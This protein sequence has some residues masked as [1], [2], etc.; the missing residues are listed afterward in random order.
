MRPGEGEAI[1]QYVQAG[2]RIPRRGEVGLSADEIS[3]FEDIGYVMSGSRCVLSTSPKKQKPSTTPT[4][5]GRT[6]QSI[7]PTPF[8]E[9]PRFQDPLAVPSVARFAPMSDATGCLKCSIHS[10]W[11][12]ASLRCAPSLCRWFFCCGSGRCTWVVAVVALRCAC[13]N[14]VRS[15]GCKES[16]RECAL[17][18]WFQMVPNKCLVDDNGTIYE[19]DCGGWCCWWGVGLIHGS[20]AFE[21]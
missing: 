19:T 11:E 13:R 21:P 9:R 20:P 7:K 18:I 1:A 8:N 10:S 6:P 12:L 17:F 4:T 2:K 5:R 16:A 15:Y 3:H 14:V